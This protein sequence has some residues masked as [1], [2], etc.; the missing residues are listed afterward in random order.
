MKYKSKYDIIMNGKIF[1]SR[2][3]VV[4]MPHE[5]PSSFIKIEEEIKVDWKELAIEAGLEGED[6]K[7]FMKKN[8]LQ[9][10]KQ[11]EKLRIK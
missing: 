7:K 8:A 2:G 10:Q 11:L 1:K 6:L 3:G 4:E 9:K 5:L